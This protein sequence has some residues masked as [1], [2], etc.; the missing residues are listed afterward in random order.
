[1]PPRL[2]SPVTTRATSLPERGPGRSS[3]R[4]LHLVPVRGGWA[5][6]RLPDEEI[7]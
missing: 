1:M 6:W 3:G 2:T 7:R 4:A 5:V